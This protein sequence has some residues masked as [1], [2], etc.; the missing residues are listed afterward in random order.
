[1]SHRSV[2][3]LIK[4][5]A[6]S[7]AD[8]IQFGYGRRSDFNLQ[9]TPNSDSAPSGVWMWLQPLSANPT[10]TNNSNTENYQKT[11]NCILLILIPDKSD[12]TEKEYKVQLDEADELADKF[13]NRLNDWAYKTSDTVGPVTLQNFQQNPIIKGDADIFSGWWVSFQMVTS[14]DFDYCTPENID[15]YAN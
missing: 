10:Y 5:T 3:Q 14:D 2:V 7:L 8:N 12:S 1:M 11:W 6:T 9:T 15:L 13:I 4:D